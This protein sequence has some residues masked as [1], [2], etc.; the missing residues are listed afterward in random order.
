MH[1][2]RAKKDFTLI[3]GRGIV[4]VVFGVSVLTIAAY[5]LFFAYD[6]L[7][8]RSAGSARLQFLFFAGCVLV[9][10]A[11]VLLLA[12][13][14]PVLAADAFFYVVAALSFLC[15][16]L[17]VK[18][19]FFRLP[20]GTYS[21]AEQGRSVYQHG[22]YAFC[23]HPGV[24]WYCLGFLFLAL[25]FRSALVTLSCLLLCAG[26]VAYMVFQDTW[27]FPRTFCDYQEYQRNVP[28]FFPTCQS[29][30]NAM[31]SLSVKGG[32]A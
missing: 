10:A 24:F 9:V 21:S 17:M 25:A 23:R 5:G 6:I 29:V 13:Q 20:R 31:S 32:R 7:T 1:R 8:V 2:C 15:F 28:V 3:L 22:M 4:A 18:A 19:L 27:S 16:V 30:S 14:M 11:F 26:N 12:S